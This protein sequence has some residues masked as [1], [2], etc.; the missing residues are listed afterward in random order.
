MNKRIV[1]VEININ[2]IRVVKL[3]DATQG[4]KNTH[5]LGLNFMDNIDLAGYMLQAYYLPPFPSTTPY[6]D[7]FT[8]LQ[9]KMEIPIPNRV[10]ERNGEV[11]IEFALT[12]GDE[13]I[14]INQ[15]FTIEVIKTI[16][17]TSLTAYPEGTLK[18]T[19]AQQIEKIKAL[20]SQTDE[21]IEEYNNNATSKTNEFNNNSLEKIGVFNKNVEKKSTDFNNHIDETLHTA[22]TNLDNKAIESA[23]LAATEANKKV[24][25]QE[26]KSIQNVI[27]EA[28]K[29]KKL[30]VSQGDAEIG[31]IEV[32]SKEEIKK[33]VEEGD[34]QKS[35]ITNQGNA[36]KKLVNDAGVAAT[37]K[38][39]NDIDTARD[40]AIS[41]ASND[42]DNYVRTT[43]LPS[44]DTYVET[45]SK[46]NIDD[47]VTT[48]ETE[49]KGATFKPSISPTGDLSFTND[50]GLPN[51]ETVNIKG[52]QG[53][54]GNFIFTV[55]NGD[56]KFYAVENGKPPEFSL[57]GK[58]LIMKI[59]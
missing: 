52:P 6:V 7:T 1:N 36:S 59:K 29:Q 12:K 46:K 42:I 16:N 37:N 58:D 32:K 10:L 27:Q 47:Y 22:Y 5:L 15:N 31:K 41:K 18:E 55:E 51:P 39:V 49:I 25:A 28:D 23:N 2:G 40:E 35:E 43:S 11:T 4:D 20:L 24:V 8:E 3:A 26:G 19:I 21:K 34:K 50:K 54:P 48:K 17:G 44:I 57:K 38:A 30:V 14:T 9:Q 45:T 33:V 13:I 56:L 53:D